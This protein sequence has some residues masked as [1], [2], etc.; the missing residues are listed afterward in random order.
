MKKFLLSLFRVCNELY[1]V[2]YKYVITSI[3]IFEVV[4]MTGPHRINIINR[5]TLGGHIQNLFVCVCLFKVISYCLYEV[6]FSTTCRSIYKERIICKPRSFKHGFCCSMC[7]L[8]EGTNNK[9]VKSVTRIQIIALI[10][11]ERL[12]IKRRVPLDGYLRY[13]TVRV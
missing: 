9:G 7:K 12:K 4:G 2:H 11:I 8:I 5:K 1:I 13:F 6:C 10:D 3:L